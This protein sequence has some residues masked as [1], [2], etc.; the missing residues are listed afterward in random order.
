METDLCM[1][2]EEKLWD[3]WRFVVKSYIRRSPFKAVCEDVDS[4]VC[5]AGTRI[6]FFEKLYRNIYDEI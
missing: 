4:D 3:E 5:I 1:E 6:P 2:T